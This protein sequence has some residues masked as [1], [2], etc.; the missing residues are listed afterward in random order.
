MLENG[1]TERFSY[2][3]SVVHA[4]CLTLLQCDIEAAGC[5]R[6]TEEQHRLVESAVQRSSTSVT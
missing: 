3:P 4:P 2:N 5:E 1:K 6:S